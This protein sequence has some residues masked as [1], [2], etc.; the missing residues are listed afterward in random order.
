MT[1]SVERFF[2]ISVHV[3]RFTGQ[4]SFGAT[5]AAAETILCRVRYGA[6]LVRNT[7]GDQVV[8]QAHVTTFVDTPQIPVGSLVTIPSHSDQERTVIVEER[9]DTG[10]PHMPNHYTFDL[11]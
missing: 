9:H 3:R 7:A 6:R 1:Q 10:L 2:T 5:Y 11:D 4:G 8:S